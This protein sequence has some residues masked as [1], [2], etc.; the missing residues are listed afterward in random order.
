MRNKQL[1][2]SGVPGSGGPELLYVHDQGRPQAS[3]VNLRPVTDPRERA[4]CRSLLLQALTL[5]DAS[6]PTA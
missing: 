5:L 6:E 3:I 4:Q 2:E 1:R